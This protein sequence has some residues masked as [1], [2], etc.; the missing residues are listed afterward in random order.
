MKLLLVVNIGTADALRFGLSASTEGSIVELSDEA[1]AK[2]FLS[3]GWA[4]AAPVADEPGP[5][6]EAA[7]EPA[8][9][10]PTKRATAK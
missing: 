3:R 8:P 1:E 6:T 10:K 2:H 9:S 4:V 7:V 5:A